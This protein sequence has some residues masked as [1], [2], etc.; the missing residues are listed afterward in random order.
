MLIFF[1]IQLGYTSPEQLRNNNVN[2][3]AAFFQESEPVAPLIRKYCGKTFTAWDPIEIRD[4]RMT[5][6][7]LLDY[8]KTQGIDIELIGAGN[9]LLYA[10]FRPIAGKLEKR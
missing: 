8:M 5:L 7:G 2:L 3:N 6:Q 1:K 4:S 10:S 9:A